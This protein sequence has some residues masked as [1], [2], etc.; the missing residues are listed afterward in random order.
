[1]NTADV[2]FWAS[3]KHFEAGLDILADVI[4]SP[5]F[6]NDEL[7]KEK[8]NIL[9]WQL[10]ERDDMFR[11]P[12]KLLYAN[13]FKNHPYGLSSLGDEVSIESLNREHVV[14]WYFEQFAADNLTVVLVGDLE[15]E[16]ALDLINTR[17]SMLRANGTAPNGRVAATSVNEI[18]ECSDE[19]KKEQTALALGFSGPSYLEEDYYALI[20]LQNVLSGLGGRFFEEL[21]SRQSLAYTVLTF[22]V[23]RHAGGAFVS[24]IATSPDKEEV[25]RE[26]LLREFE[27]LLSAPISEEEL[28]QAIKYTTGTHQI[29]LETNGAQMSQY[30]HNEL[31]GKGISGI[32]EF[33]AKIKKVTSDDILRAARKYFDLDGYALGVVR[34]KNDDMPA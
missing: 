7:G 27:K 11:Y 19:R 5:T 28:S 9:A 17:F 12:L 3:S 18:V 13:L 23:S 2:S 6:A 16:K 22:L 1:M 25:A 20:V 29:A 4:T 14:S 21:R 24:Y 31:I 32:E 30:A 15:S 34:G 33:P 26:G 8:D 10:R